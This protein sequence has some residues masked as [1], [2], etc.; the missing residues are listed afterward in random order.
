M[1]PSIT[2]G[3]Q[4]EK[5]EADTDYQEIKVGFSLNST[6]PFD[7]YSQACKFPVFNHEA[8]YTEV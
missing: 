8:F 2:G 3:I 6:V 5:L 1:E 7:K 4:T